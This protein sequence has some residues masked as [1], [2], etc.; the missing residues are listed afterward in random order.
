M[1]CWMR[2]RGHGWPAIGEMSAA[3]FVPLA[4]LIGPFWADAISG[5]MLLGAM[6]LLMLPAMVVAMLHR[7]EEYTQ[8][9]R[10]HDTNPTR[11]AA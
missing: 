4:V 5:E 2:H 6:H 8:D 11:L 7:R 9:H 10:R 1:A 3:M